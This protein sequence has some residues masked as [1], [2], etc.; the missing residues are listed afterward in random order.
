MHCALVLRPPPEA[1]EYFT[2]PKRRTKKNLRNAKIKGGLAGGLRLTFVLT[3]TDSLS[4]FEEQKWMAQQYLSAVKIYNILQRQHYSP[5]LLSLHKKD[6]WSKFF[7]EL[8]SLSPLEVWL[9]VELAGILSLLT[10]HH[11][12]DP[13]P[14]LGS[15]AV[16]GFYGLPLPSLSVEKKSFSGH[17]LLLGRFAGEEEK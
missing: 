2:P 15:R 10:F 4:S 12:E 17:D 1:A 6:K 13:T 9:E 7:I 11:F 8:D 14:L 16:G 5:F 3:R